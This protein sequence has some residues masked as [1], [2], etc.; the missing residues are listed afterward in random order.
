MT[1]LQVCPITSYYSFWRANSNLLKCIQDFMPPWVAKDVLLL[2]TSY[3]VDIIIWSGELAAAYTLCTYSCFL[4]KGF[5]C[6]NHTLMWMFTDSP[7]GRKPLHRQTDQLAKE[8]QQVGSRNGFL[9]V[10]HN[11]NFHNWLNYLVRSW[12]AATFRIYPN[13]Y[14][15]AL[16]FTL[17]YSCWS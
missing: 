9:T 6:L 13:S 2:K 1:G 4:W 7:G 17:R 10:S 14:K 8:T 15:I 12:N 5:K 3:S 11:L 16:I